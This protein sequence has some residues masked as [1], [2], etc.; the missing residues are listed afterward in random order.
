MKKL[1]LFILLFT[2]MVFD[3]KAAESDLFPF[4]ISYDDEKNVTS[5]SQLL[6]GP[7]GKDG[8]VRIENGRFVTDAGPIR[9]HATNLTGP[10]NFPTHAEADKLARRLARFGINCVRLHYFD[11]EYGTFML[12]KL[13]G[14]IKLDPAT[15]RQL[16]AKQ[17]DKQDYL[18]AAFKKQ[19]IY[20]DM[21]LHVA[22][23]WDER[24][25]FPAG[26]P[27]ADKGLDNIEPRMIELQKEYAKQLLTHVNPYTGNAYINEPAIAMIEINNE[28]AFLQM[29]QGGNL[30]NLAAPYILAIEK[31]WNEWL[32]K[33]YANTEDLKKAW[34]SVSSALGTELIPEG[35][36][37]Q[38]VNLSKDKNWTIQKGTSEATAES[39]KGVLCVSVKKEG[40]EFFPKLFRTV[41]IQKDQIYTFSLKIRQTKGTTGGRLGLALAGRGNGW[42]PLGLL[43]YYKSSSDWKKISFVFQATESCRNAQFQ[44]TRF[45]VGEYEIDDLS[46][47]TGA[48]KGYEVNG[49]LEKGTIPF[50]KR[51]QFVPKQIRR[52]FYEFICDSEMRYWT[53]INRYLKDE[54][55]A[56]QVVS[57]TQLGYSP[58]Y[59]QGS[60]DYVDNHSYWCHP[61]PVSPD[62]KIRNTAMV[63]SLANIWGLAGAR[64]HNKPYTISEYNHPFPNLYGTEGQLL[65]R[66]YGRLQGWDG[67]FEYTYNH[68]PNFEPDRNTYFFSI[69]ARTD[70][71]AHFPACAAIYLRGD[72]QEARQTVS[73]SVDRKTYLDYLSSGRGI[74]YGISA[75]GYDPRNTLVH[76]TAIDPFGTNSDYLNSVNAATESK[77]DQKNITLFDAQ[78]L[79]SDTG[80]IR[81]N[82]EIPGFCYWTVNTTN[83]KVFTGFPKDR[84]IELGNVSLKI[85]KTMLDWATVSMTSKNAAGFGEKGKTSVLIA[86]TGYCGNKDMK[87][88]KINKDTIKL[89]D[90]GTGPTVAEGIPAEIVFPADSAKA[91]CFAL[92]PAGKRK[93]EVPVKNNG[94]GKS[95]IVIGPQYKTVWY[96]FIAE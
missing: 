85:G 33:K 60:L 19:G 69:I 16:D 31:A 1:L 74:T 34:K 25:G 55:K 9:F 65:L 5:M 30:D 67:V 93:M 63:N 18:I 37:E 84:T 66:T 35:K 40:G 17:R 15:Q 94:N 64:V 28:N 92:D 90:W 83:T 4:L 80:E 81:W 71:L 11:A 8:F 52:D 39:K 77:A 7:A 48:V 68:S 22:R 76:K 46:F 54:L 86:A 26:H 87:I 49:T 2:G 29:Y 91:K 73:A 13:P 43:E 21:N 14:I 88:N 51:S 47:R 89:D 12:E 72:V 45:G 62:W 70:V 78:E 58:A 32:K 3:L 10:A 79:T 50:V 42:Q 57:G 96:E 24:D 82:K 36:F 41:D 6:D 56:K 95:K 53:G 38:P 27:W 75:A 59:V 23:Y 61:S 44:L 20:V